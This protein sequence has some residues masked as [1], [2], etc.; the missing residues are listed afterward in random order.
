MTADELSQVYE[1]LG[2][3]VQVEVIRTEVTDWFAGAALAV[4]LIA[5]AGSLAWSGRLP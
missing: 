1:D 3:S 5:A 4:M 2:R